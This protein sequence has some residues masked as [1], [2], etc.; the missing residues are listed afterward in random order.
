MSAFKRISNR[1]VK[2]SDGYGHWCPACEEIHLFS[3]EK[4]NYS[5]A[6]WQY[7]GDVN[8][9]TFSPSMRISYDNKTGCHYTLTD[10]QITFHSDSPHSLSG[11]TVPLP[12][13]PPGFW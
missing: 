8:T 2:W 11:Q 6:I 4:R 12:D 1:L 10:G 3:T 9:P 13:L 5:N 7:N